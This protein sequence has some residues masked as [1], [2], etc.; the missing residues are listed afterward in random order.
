MRSLPPA[1]DFDRIGDEIAI[2]GIGHGDALAEEI[3]H[4]HP[5]A[6]VENVGVGDDDDIDRL[7]RGLELGGHGRRAVLVT[8]ALGGIA[9]GRRAFVGL[10]LVGRVLGRLFVL[11]LGKPVGEGGL[12]RPADRAA[13]VSFWPLDLK[14]WSR[15][16]TSGI[17]LEP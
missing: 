9:G 10:V 5:E 3:L 14:S 13:S 17:A 8:G 15:P 4:L 12:G 6:V 2:A 7:R 1:S 16:E 11:G